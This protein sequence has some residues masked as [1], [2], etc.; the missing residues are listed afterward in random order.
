M[1]QLP[2]TAAVLLAALVSASADCVPTIEHTLYIEDDLG[3]PIVGAGPLL[4]RVLITANGTIPGPEIRV[5]VND[6]VKVRSQQLRA[7]SVDV[8]ITIRQG[9]PM[10]NVPAMLPPRLP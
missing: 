1:P 6:C 5:K 2:R 4:E 8:S 9:S 10:Q 3:S 7:A